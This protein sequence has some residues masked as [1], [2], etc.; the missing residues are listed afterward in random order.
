MAHYK[1]VQYAPAVDYSRTPDII[2]RNKRN[3]IKEARRMRNK[4]IELRP[5][6]EYKKVNK[7]EGTVPYCF[8]AKHP[9][10][11]VQYQVKIEPI[12]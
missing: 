8:Q 3:A 6:T 5:R 10:Y 7:K 1:L 9:F 4:F 12:Y 2:K 11:G